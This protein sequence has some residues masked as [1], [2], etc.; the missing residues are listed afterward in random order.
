[1]INP[2]PSR[3][4]RIALT[5]IVGPLVVCVLMLLLCFQQKQTLADCDKDKQIPLLALGVS[6]AV[7]A[8]LSKPPL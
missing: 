3:S 1:M 4:D 5:A 2:P 8:W 7:F 6:T